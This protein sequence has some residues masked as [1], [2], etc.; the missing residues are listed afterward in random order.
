MIQERENKSIFRRQRLCHRLHQIRYW[1]R[2]VGKKALI[3][4][5]QK[6]WK[7]CV[8]RECSVLPRYVTPFLRKQLWPAKWIRAPN[9]HT[10]TI[11][12]Y[13]LTF[14]AISG[15]KIYVKIRTCSRS[16]SGYAPSLMCLWNSNRHTRY[17]HA[18]V[19]KFCCARKIHHLTIHEAPGPRHWGRCEFGQIWINRFVMATNTI[20]VG[21]RFC[22]EVHCNER[23]RKG[24]CE[25]GSLLAE[26]HASTKL[27]IV[28]EHLYA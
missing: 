22:S 21:R 4:Q 24:T 8:P 6:Q 27:S 25:A 13:G 17:V 9:T 14:L 1:P 11:S 12:R 5:A 19:V 23:W 18:T 16:I 10:S 26:I 3:I 15:T 28:W 2:P 7:R 20:V